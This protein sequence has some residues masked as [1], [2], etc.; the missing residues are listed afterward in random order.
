ML[1]PISAAVIDGAFL[2]L[3]K[4]AVAYFQLTPF[5]RNFIKKNVLQLQFNYLIG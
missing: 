2:G 5:N 4:T 3:F 1:A